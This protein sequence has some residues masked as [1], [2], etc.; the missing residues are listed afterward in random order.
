ME[1]QFNLYMLYTEMEWKKMGYTVVIDFQRTVV[2]E[3]ETITRKRGEVCFVTVDQLREFLVLAE[4][5]N[6]Q[7]A[8]DTLYISQ[9]TLSRHMISLEKEL[10]I[11][12]FDRMA[13][14]NILSA[15]GRRFLVRA[16]NMVDL[17]DSCLQ[18]IQTELNSQEGDLSIAVLRNFTYYKVAD[19]LYDFMRQH[20][21]ITVNVRETSSSAM[22]QMLSE[23]H[24]SFAFISELGHTINDQ[25]S[26]E[27]VCTDTMAICLPAS[28]PL[29]H[30]KEV[31]LDQLK[32]ENFLM[33]PQRG[34]LYNA[35]LLACRRS[36]FDPQINFTV[37]GNSIYKFVSNELCVALLLK[38]PAMAVHPKD[39]CLVDLTPPIHIWLNMLYPKRQ[40]NATETCFLNFARSYISAL[41]E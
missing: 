14:T 12:L 21:H 33:A 36:G 31:T 34:N 24:C 7:R 8:A 9:A 26:R 22:R 5:G 40:L 20:P 15:A 28:H 35:C 17:A 30:C 38:T 2:I 41:G 29:A 23:G 11:T 16:R 13:H 1:S 3:C 6:Y 25:F 18:R 37:S 32:D 10:G 19:L 27:P 39:T 4:I